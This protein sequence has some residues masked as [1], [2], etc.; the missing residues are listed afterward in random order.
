MLL[1]W[2][3][4]RVSGLSNEPA[5]LAVFINVRVR[6]YWV[7]GSVGM[8][9]LNLGHRS[10]NNDGSCSGHASCVENRLLGRVSTFPLCYP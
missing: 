4:G 5:A 1:G 2:L 6:P 8:V 10:G 7:F 3:A 9:R